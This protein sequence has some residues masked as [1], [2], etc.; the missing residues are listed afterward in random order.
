MKMED[1][2]YLYKMNGS[3]DLTSRNF[4]TGFAMSVLCRIYIRKN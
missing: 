3:L 4:F 2:I 1:E